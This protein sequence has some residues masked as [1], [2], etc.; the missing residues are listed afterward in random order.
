MTTDALAIVFSPNLLRA[1][2]NDFLMIMSN[3]QHTNKL[4]KALVTHVR[5]L[6]FSASTNRSFINYSST[7]F[8]TKRKRKRIKSTMTTN[9]TNPFSRRMKRSKQRT[10]ATQRNEIPPLS[11]RD[12]ALSTLRTKLLPNSPLKYFIRF[13]SR[14]LTPRHFRAACCT[15]TAISVTQ[16]FH[17]ILRALYIHIAWHWTLVPSPIMLLSICLSVVGIRHHLLVA[18]DPPDPLQQLCSAGRT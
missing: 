10:R 5:V 14:S 9:L 12:L 8:S 2:H 13:I 15:F 6:E 1:P 3:M 17:Y 18:G 4:V 16:F 11:V 7:L